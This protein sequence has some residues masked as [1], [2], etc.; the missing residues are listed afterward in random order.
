[1][2]QKRE[3]GFMSLIWLQPMFASSCVCF[4]FRHDL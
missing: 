3:K 1:L 4:P 2:V